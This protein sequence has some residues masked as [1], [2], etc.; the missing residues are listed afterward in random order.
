MNQFLMEAN[1]RNGNGRNLGAASGAGAP[2]PGDAG[3]GRF[4]ER[5]ESWRF[6]FAKPVSTPAAAVMVKLWKDRRAIGDGD[7]DDVVLK[8]ITSHTSTKSQ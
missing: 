2:R 8:Q 3:M 7:G 5:A 6:N 1:I 4:C